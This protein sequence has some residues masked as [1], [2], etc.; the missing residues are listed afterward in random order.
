[1]ICLNLHTIL[2][3]SDGKIT[4]KSKSAITLVAASAQDKIVRP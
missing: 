4:Q 1:M 2:I 3:I